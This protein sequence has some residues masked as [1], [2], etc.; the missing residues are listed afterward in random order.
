[1]CDEDGRCEIWTVILWS[2]ISTSDM[3]SG[4]PSHSHCITKANPNLQQL[5][6]TLISLSTFLGIAVRIAVHRRQNISHE[7][8]HRYGCLKRPFCWWWS[9]AWESVNNNT[10]KELPS[11]YCSVKWTCPKVTFHQNNYQITKSNSNVPF[12]IINSSLHSF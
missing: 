8:H 11:S 2:E 5:I 7:I 9:Q 1:M 6:P 4:S 12:Y 10:I 3:N